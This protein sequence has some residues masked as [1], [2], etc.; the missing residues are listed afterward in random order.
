MEGEF[1]RFLQDLEH[2]GEKLRDLFVCLCVWG[3][4]GHEILDLRNVGLQPT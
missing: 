4:S 2:G 1:E 3:G